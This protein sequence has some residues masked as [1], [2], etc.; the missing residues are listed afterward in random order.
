[1]HLGQKCHR[2]D[3]MFS[4]H[5]I[6]GYIISI[7][8]ITDGI[9]VTTYLVKL[10]SANNV[11]IFFLLHQYLERVTLRLCKNPVSPQTF[12]HYFY[13]PSVDLAC[14]NY[15][16]CICLIE[17]LYISHLFYWNFSIKNSCSF[18]L[19]YLFNYI[20]NMDSWVFYSMGYNSILSLLILFLKLLNFSHLELFGLVYVA[21]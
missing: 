2:N 5:L 17:I 3:T 6:R 11:T 15:Y 13:H 1:M 9:K 18:S 16:C 14:N 12:T 4:M 19:I 7:H 10:I 21:F 20:Y 8:L